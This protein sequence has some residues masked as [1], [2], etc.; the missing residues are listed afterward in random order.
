M[1]NR[2][3]RDVRQGVGIN[4]PRTQIPNPANAIA[5][6]VGRRAPS[7]PM[8]GRTINPMPQLPGSPALPRPGMPIARPGVPTAPAAAPTATMPA[9][10]GQPVVPSVTGAPRLPI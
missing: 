9:R 10:P 6:G 3:I 2:S 7:A 1:A 4:N 8:P 5:Q